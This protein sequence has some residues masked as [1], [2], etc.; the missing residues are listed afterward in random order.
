MKSPGRLRELQ[1]ILLLKIP[2]FLNPKKNLILNK[3]KIFTKLL[4]NIINTKRI[5]QVK[6]LT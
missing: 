5:K 1:V 6:Y 2:H 3:I 4:A